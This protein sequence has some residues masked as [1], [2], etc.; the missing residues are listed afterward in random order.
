MLVPRVNSFQCAVLPLVQ[1]KGVHALPQ[2]QILAQTD[3]VEGG[4][5]VEIEHQ[6]GRGD[7]VV[8]S[9]VR[10]AIVVEDVFRGKLPGA[11]ARVARRQL[12]F[13]RQ[14]G[15]EGGIENA[16][17]FSQRLD[18]V[19]VDESAAVRRDVQVQTGAPADGLVVN[20]EQLGR[21]LDATHPRWH[22]RTSRAGSKRRTPP[23]ARPCRDVRRRSG[24]HWSR[25]DSGR[26]CSCSTSPS[27][28]RRRCP[29]RCPPSG[30]PA[31]RR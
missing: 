31:R 15:R 20:V 8:R 27:T 2:R 10:G 23:A 29:S 19:F 12:A 28:D 30:S 22:D 11:A 25:R 21:R 1:R 3:H 5:F 16:A 6:L 17:E 24:P 26:A 4:R 13:L 14:V 9:P 18:V 7:A